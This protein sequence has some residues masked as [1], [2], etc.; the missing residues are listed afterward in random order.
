MISAYQAA[1]TSASGALVAYGD[2]AAAH[3]TDHNLLT[4]IAQLSQPG[5]NPALDDA[6]TL[7]SRAVTALQ[8]AAATIRSQTEQARA[9]RGLAGADVA[10]I[11]EAITSGNLDDAQKI[12]AQ[13]LATV[14]PGLRGWPDPI[15]P[16]GQKCPLDWGQPVP[17]LPASAI[18]AI[19]ELSDRLVCL[20]GTIVTTLDTWFGTAQNSLASARDDLG[21]TA[22]QAAQDGLAQAEAGITGASD[23]LTGMLTGPVATTV[24]DDLAAI[25]TSQAN[26][27]ASVERIL[28]DLT[29]SAQESVAQLT[30]QVE[31][32]SGDSE[33]ARQQLQA[34]F[35]RVMANLGDP[36][37]ANRIGL[38]G[39]L[40]DA[41]DQVGI[42][43]TQVS[44]TTS[45]VTGYAAGLQTNLSTLDLYDAQVNAA[46]QRLHDWHPFADQAG[47]T[48]FTYR[49]QGS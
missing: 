16:G 48:V 11:Q 3:D 7:L 25:D 15:Q 12:V 33:T 38:L 21:L 19:V 26:A 14:L 6:S 32:A 49:M 29:A 44:G 1:A 4:T 46:Q 42:A 27:Q 41:A 10:A 22:A 35:S 40:H 39:K 13:L 45:D 34:A 31:Q 20:N 28:T 36:E 8:S 24:R 43:A 47:T 23:A 9:A 18:N 2:A 17:D 5:T 37:P 30:A